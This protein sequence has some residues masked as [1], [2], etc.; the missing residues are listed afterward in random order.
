MVDEALVKLAK[1]AR[2]LLN[3]DLGL[4]V[5]DAYR[6]RRVTLAMIDWAE[7]S[8]NIHLVE[9]GYIARR[10]RHNSGAAIDLSRYCISTELLLDMGT[11]WDCFIKESHLYNV[12]GRSLQN[13]LL[14]LQIMKNQ[15]F[16]GYEK[17]W[18][19]FE[20]YN[21][22][23]YQLRDFPYGAEERNEDQKIC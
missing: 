20:L 3:K 8:G 2:K 17:E 21:A 12:Q 1:V 13:R 15:G 5:W 22:R 6:P 10:S 18:W 4:Y 14:L 16:V 7:R 9:D 19:H 23:D 11:E